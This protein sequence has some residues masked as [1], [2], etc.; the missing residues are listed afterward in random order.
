LK[1]AYLGF[2]P[3]SPSGLD[4]EHLD[5]TTVLR[6]DRPALLDAAFAGQSSDGE[7]R[8]IVVLNWLDDVTRLVSAQ[9]GTGR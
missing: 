4:E 9:G 7:E 8:I 2:L 3:P 5:L 6:Q 1:C